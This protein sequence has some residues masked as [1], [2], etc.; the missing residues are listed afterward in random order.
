MNTNK[1]VQRQ[2]I[3]LHYTATRIR[4]DPDCPD[5][6]T[7]TPG[8]VVHDGDYPVHTPVDEWIE[9]GHWAVYEPKPVAADTAMKG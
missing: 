5:F 6:Q 2:Y 8:D 9:S 3:V 1:A 4:P 7:F